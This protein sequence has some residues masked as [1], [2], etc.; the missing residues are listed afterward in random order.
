VTLTILYALLCAAIAVRLVTFRRG[1]S[2]H[3]PLAAC[4]AYALA[5]AA[6][7]APIRALFGLLPPVGLGTTV[8]VGVLCV[9]VYG[10]RGNV[11]HLLWSA[12][13]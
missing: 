12:R 3:R 7:V 4:A 6:G 13:R 8:L 1:A 2:N 9:A 11:A 10:V 5:V